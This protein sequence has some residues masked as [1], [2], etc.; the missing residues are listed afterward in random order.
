MRTGHTVVITHR[1][2]IAIVVVVVVSMVSAPIGGV[3]GQDAVGEQG[4]D[5]EVGLGLVKA[6]EDKG[7]CRRLQRKGERK[8]AMD[9]RNRLQGRR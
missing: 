4:V 3:D 5:W 9:R 8:G 1:G 6:M 7:V 2:R